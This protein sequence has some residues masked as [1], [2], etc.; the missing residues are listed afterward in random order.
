MASLFLVLNDPLVAGRIRTTLETE[1]GLQ[2]VGWATTLAQACEAIEDLKPQLVLSDLELID[3][4]VEELV[5]E[6]GKSRYGRPQTLVL[7]RSLADGRVMDV[8]RQGA[9]GY[10]LVEHST[11]PLAAVVRQVLAGESPMAPEIA[12][13][14]SAHFDEFAGEGG[15]VVGESQNTLRPSDAERQLLRLLTE[16]R[17][18]GQIATDTDTSAHA[19][20]TKVRLLY[21]KLRYDTSASTLSL[22]LI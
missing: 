10:F 6:L 9:D 14:I 21:R 19:L 16:G 17:A 2:I 20:G 15:D 13:H 11:Q 12:R 5:A 3:G 4:L 8:M 1:P 18:L 22:T 7:A